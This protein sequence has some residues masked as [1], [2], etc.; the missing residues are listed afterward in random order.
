MA[1]VRSLILSFSL[2]LAVWRFFPG[3]L[4][5]DFFVL[6]LVV[7]DLEQGRVCVSWVRQGASGLLKMK[8][9]KE[10]CSFPAAWREVGEKLKESTEEVGD[11]LLPALK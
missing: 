4:D 2:S 7:E 8:Q 10:I 9:S 11:R 3:Y 1:L 5:L 6:E